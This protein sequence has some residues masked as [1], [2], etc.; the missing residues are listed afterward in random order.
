[1]WF[2]EC[3][4]VNVCADFAEGGKAAEAEKTERTPTGRKIVLREKLTRQFDEAAKSATSVR[5]GLVYHNGVWL[6]N[7]DLVVEKLAIGDELVPFRFIRRVMTV[8]CGG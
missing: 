3:V 6:W 5:F 7:R 2:C 4:R 1:M 8:A